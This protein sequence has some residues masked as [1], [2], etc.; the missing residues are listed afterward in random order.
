MGIRENFYCECCAVRSTR[1][2]TDIYSDVDILHNLCKKC[3][4]A[5]KK[6]YT[7]QE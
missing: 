1:F 6:S 2:K 7:Y 3:K 4:I 5:I